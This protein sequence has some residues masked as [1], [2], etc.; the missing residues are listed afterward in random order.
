[1]RRPASLITTCLLLLLSVSATA[2]NSTRVPGYTIH[3]N[4][5]T[6]DI[7]DPKVASNYGIK[8]SKSR[9]MINISVI[10]EIPG[11]TGKPVPARVRVSARNLIGQERQIPVREIRD[12]DA[13]YYIGDF[14][15]AHRERL[16][17]LIEVIPEGERLPYRARMTHEFYTD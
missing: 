11:T 14:P 7:L 4:A 5:L 17:F 10:K 13:V 3:H 12:G 1:M 16:N 9:A 6:T 8:R 15:V 2:E